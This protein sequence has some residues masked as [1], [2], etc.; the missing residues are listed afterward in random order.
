MLCLVLLTGHANAV[1]QSCDM[2][3]E[4]E[5][6]RQAERDRRMSDI[7]TRFEE[8]NKIND[9]MRACLDN[10]PSYPTQLPSS[11]IFVEAFKKIKQSACEQLVKKAREQYDAAMRQAQQAAAQAGINNI[12]TIPNV[13]TPTVGTVPTT[14]VPVSGSQTSGVM[15][16]LRRFFQ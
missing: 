8:L 12:P 6:Q 2:S 14:T 11:A 7:D 1:V 15:D 9:L 10:F 3:K 13:T 5:R 16:S 4:I